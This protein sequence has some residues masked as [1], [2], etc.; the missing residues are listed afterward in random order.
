MTE[1]DKWG[2]SVLGPFV[3]IRIVKTFHDCLDV[4]ISNKLPKEK[5]IVEPRINLFKLGY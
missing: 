4:I 5:K 2:H 3:Y 1:G